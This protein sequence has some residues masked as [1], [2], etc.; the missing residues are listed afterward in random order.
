MSYPRSQYLTTTSKIAG[1]VMEMRYA[2]TKHFNLESNNK[3]LQTENILLREKLPMS[4]MKVGVGQVKINDTLY[5]EQYD[6][7]PAQII[8]STVHKQ[9]NFFTINVGSIQGIKPK[10]GVFSANGIVGEVFFVSEHYSLIRSVLSERSHINVMIGPDRI[11]G[12]IEWDGKDADFGYV[13]ILKDDSKIKIGSL[14]TTLPPDFPRGLKVGTVTKITE[15]EEDSG[16][17]PL[18]YIKFSENY[19]TLQN[20]YVIVDKLRSEYD[21]L[22][23]SIPSE[24]K[25]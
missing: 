21:Q 13:S 5:H 18:I 14:V 22:Q 16:L 15:V 6:Y 11:P 7:I 2:I 8:N 19:R 25:Q 4:F 9:N 3:A 17:K 10:M 1:S 12:I 20:V 24:N 23:L